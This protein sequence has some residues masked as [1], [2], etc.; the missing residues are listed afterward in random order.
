MFKKIMLFTVTLFTGSVAFAQTPDQVCREHEEDIRKASTT[1]ENV[2]LN[3]AW[4]SEP[5]DIHGNVIDD[6]NAFNTH[7][8]MTFYSKERRRGMVNTTKVILI[9]P[10]GGWR[11]PFL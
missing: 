7:C 8:N 10:D 2:R 3:K 5:T 11:S 9:Y 4:A 6:D 1:Y